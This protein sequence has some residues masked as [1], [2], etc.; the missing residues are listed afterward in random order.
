MSLCLVTLLTGFL[1]PNPWCLAQ[2]ESRLHID[3]AETSNFL[4]KAKA[5]ELTENFAHIFRNDFG[6]GKSGHS[7]DVVVGFSTGQILLPVV[8]RILHL[9]QVRMH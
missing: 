7:K 6:I 8:V 4:S 3:A 2:E 9:R 5:R 1:D